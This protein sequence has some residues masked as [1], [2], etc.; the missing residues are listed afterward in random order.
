MGGIGIWCMHF[1]GNR[2]VILHDTASE[3]QISYSAAFTAISFF[4][5]IVVLIMAFYF[6]GISERTDICY[7]LLS[8]GMTGAAVCGM[9]YVGQLGIS[10]YRCSNYVGNVVAAAVIAVVASTI[11]LGVFFRLRASWA[12]NWWKRIITASGL[13][14]AVSG[15]H[16]TAMVGTTYRVKQLNPD[17][18]SELSS[19]QTVIVCATLVCLN[20]LLK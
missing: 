8:G 10:N 6:I 13:A 12:N 7:I 9:H 19:S 18:S 4:L 14:V 17:Q 20:S 16:W 1:I 2:A 3:T 5:P 11:A 15:M